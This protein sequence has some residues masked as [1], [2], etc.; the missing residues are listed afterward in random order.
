MLNYTKLQIQIPNYRINEL[1]KSYQIFFSENIVPDGKVINL[2]ERKTNFKKIV[3][4]QY[5]WFTNEEYEELYKLIQPQEVDYYLKCKEKMV[6]TKYKQQIIKLFCKFDCNND[7]VLDL[8]E[9]KSIMKK[10]KIKEIENIFNKMDTNDDKLISID[11]F[12]NYLVK[13]VAL[14]NKLDEV[15]EYKFQMN[16]MIDKRTIIFKDF[17]GSPNNKNWRP[18]LSQVNPFDK[19]KQKI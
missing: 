18:S 17:P 3:K 6:N 16:K 5:H 1:K 12:I 9:F 14:F 7:N 10:F 19:I 8:N 2:N 13:D 15:L 11:E 4:I